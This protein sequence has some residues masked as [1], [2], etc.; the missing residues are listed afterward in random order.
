MHETFVCDV[1]NERQ[2]DDLLCTTTSDAVSLY[3]VHC[4][5][6]PIHRG[7]DIDGTVI[8]KPPERLWSNLDERTRRHQ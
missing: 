6:C 1:C 8:W 7:E 5:T 3:C 2:P 4:C